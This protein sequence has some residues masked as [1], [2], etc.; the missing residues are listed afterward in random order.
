MALVHPAKVPAACLEFEAEV[1]VLNDAKGCVELQPGYQPIIHC[2][3]VHQAATVVRIGQ[4]NSG[5]WEGLAGPV[6]AAAKPARTRTSSNCAAHELG[7][8]TD[9]LASTVLTRGESAPAAPAGNRLSNG[10]ARQLSGGVGGRI[11]PERLRAG[12][13]CV[14]RFRFAHHPEYIQEGSSLVLRDGRARGVG[15]V[16]AVFT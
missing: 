3:T 12:D 7:A 6:T 8:G 14:V 13:H 16:V 9:A 11:V 1:L 5:T 10:I 2:R 4:D 15:R